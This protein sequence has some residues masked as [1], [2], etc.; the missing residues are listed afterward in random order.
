MDCL[1]RERERDEEIAESSGTVH[2][3]IPT[4]VH[5]GRNGTAWPLQDFF[6]ISVVV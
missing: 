3:C 2:M 6:L 1:Q 5:K 4:Y